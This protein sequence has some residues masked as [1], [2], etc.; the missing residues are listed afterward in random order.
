MK[1]RCIFLM[2]L[3]II[4]FLTACEE[5]PPPLPKA[6]NASPQTPPPTPDYTKQSSVWPFLAEDSD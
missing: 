3:P 2:L 4:F 6:P 5:E 1:K